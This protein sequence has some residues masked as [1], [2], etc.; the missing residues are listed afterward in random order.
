VADA[1][2]PAGVAEGE[3]F[4]ATTVVGHDAGNGDAEALVVSHSGLKEGYGAFRRLV[5]QDLG[6]GDAGVIVDADVDE[7]PADATVVT[8]AGAIAGDAVADLV[9]TPELLDEMWIISPG[10]SRS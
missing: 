2:L 1:Q 8:L 4:V 10:F 5:R 7:L 9:E 6:K 3:G